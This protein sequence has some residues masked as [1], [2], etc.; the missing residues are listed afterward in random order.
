M[1]IGVVGEAENYLQEVGYACKIE[2][3]QQRLS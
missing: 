2:S 1:V 3:F